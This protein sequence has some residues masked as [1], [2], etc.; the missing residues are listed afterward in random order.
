[1][2]QLRVADLRAWLKIK[3]WSDKENEII[4]WASIPKY[5]GDNDECN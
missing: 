3:E 1:M 5:E 4:T 2:V